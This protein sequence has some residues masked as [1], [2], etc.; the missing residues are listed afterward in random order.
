MWLSWWGS[1]LYFISSL[2]ES[3]NHVAKESG[4]TLA[5]TSTHPRLHVRDYVS[6]HIRGMPLKPIVM[7]AKR[8][9]LN[10]SLKT[11]RIWLS[12]GQ[13]SCSN[14]R[15]LGRTRVCLWTSYRYSLCHARLSVLY[16]A[17]SA[18]PV[19]KIMEATKFA[20]LSISQ[21]SVTSARPLPSPSINESRS[22]WSHAMIAI[23]QMYFLFMFWAHT[24]LL[25]IYVLSVRPPSKRLTEK[26]YSKRALLWH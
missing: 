12:A 22:L 7:D 8:W 26:L 23:S 25:S 4:S 14:R 18:Y 13:F 15:C 6:L 16:A 19:T 2:D 20:I 5:L 3:A 9:S 21:S 10:I 24:A 11:F 17:S 1:K